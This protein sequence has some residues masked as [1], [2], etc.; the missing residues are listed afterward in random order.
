MET[1]NTNN[2]MIAGFIVAFLVMG[3]YI[4]SMYLRS[5]NLKRDLETYR[6]LDKPAKK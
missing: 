2:Y 1:V 6:A 3:V 5:R 4:L